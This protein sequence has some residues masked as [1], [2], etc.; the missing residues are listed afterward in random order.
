MSSIAV[1]DSGIGG[2][3]VL[4]EI[5]KLAPQSDLIYLADHGYGPYGERTLS[6]VRARTELLATYLASRGVKVV[7][8]ACNSASAAALH[9]VR[10]A[11]PNLC[12]VGM[13]PA[14]KPA[15]L[16]TSVGVVAV[17]ATAVTF[18]GEL[19]RS[20][21][22]AYGNGIEVVEQACPGLAAAIEAG[23]SVAALLDRYLA[24]I[25]AAG[26]DTLVLGCTHY[27]LIKD[28]IARRLPA[29]VNIIDPSP[30][31]ARQSLVVARQA[32]IE[33]HAGGLTSWWSTRTGRSTVGD[34][35]WQTI[36]VR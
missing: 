6:E 2:T 3:S 34:R 35:R 33:L 19:F 22:E 31:V 11:L 15:A 14:L 18:Q 29:H 23:E 28:E 25:V 17:M 5:R 4:D 7:V 21:V 9:Y 26:A 32:G 1:I 16:H 27:P 10:A 8:I 20:L 36:D 13:E 12:F 24:P 30:A